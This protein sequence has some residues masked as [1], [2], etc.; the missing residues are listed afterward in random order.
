MALFVISGVPAAGKSTVA[1]LLARR[2]DKAVCVPGDTVRAMV[3]TGRADMHPDADEAEFSQLLLRYEAAL[4]VAATY[5]RAG[6][7]AV[8]EDVIIG[9]VLRDFLDLVPV[10]DVHL[11]FL[12]PDSRAIA[13]RDRDRPKTAYGERWNVDELRSVL[14]EHTR[15][16]GLWV[17]ST[18][19]TAD[20]TVDRILADL[21][22]SLVR[23]DHVWPSLRA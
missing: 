13:E 10:P 18:D 15:H 16:V 8:V 17:D 4:A 11:V 9:P 20:Q 12:D 5:L 1:Q 23:P 7:D 19:L 21:S 22:T 3:V 6:F 14:R 2:L